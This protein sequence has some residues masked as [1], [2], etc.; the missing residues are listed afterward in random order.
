M[1]AVYRQMLTDLA[2]FGIMG[3]LTALIAKDVFGIRLRGFFK[4]DYLSIGFPKTRPETVPMIEATVWVLGGPLIVLIIFWIFV[5]R[6]H[7]SNFDGQ[8]S[9]KFAILNDEIVHDDNFSN[10]PT[11]ASTAYHQLNNGDAPQSTKLLDT[12]SDSDVT[13]QP[14]EQPNKRI[15]PPSTP[16]PIPVSSYGDNI[17]MDNLI[18]NP[19][20][21]I[22]NNFQQNNNQLYGSN[23]GTVVIPNQSIKVRKLRFAFYQ[24]FVF[25]FVVMLSLFVTNSIK[26]IVGSLRPDYIAC[27][28]PDY[29]HPDLVIDKETGW[30]DQKYESII[31]R[32]TKKEILEAHK[33]FPSGHAS[34]TMVSSVFIIIYLYQ[35]FWNRGRRAF[36]S[37]LIPFLMTC[38]L[39]V[40][41]CIAA[42]R[43]IDYRHRFAD[44]IIGLIIG[45]CCAFVSL[46][47][48]PFTPSYEVDGSI[49]RINEV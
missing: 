28:D 30:I 23:W 40:A 46:L 1:K 17:K 7:S 24:L 32:G 19:T 35:R 21:T 36:G 2:I 26:N 29:N 37:L 12:S 20:K 44:L 31:C 13:V 22:T 43:H 11:S 41:L 10:Y 8:T 34:S 15:T 48:Q 47:L 33:S 6:I 14:Q 5:D 18:K 25:F 4:T 45:T 3:L 38:S 49:K 9:E 27:C 16:H 42:T 39:L